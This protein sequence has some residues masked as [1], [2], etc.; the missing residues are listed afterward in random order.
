[1]GCGPQCLKTRKTVTCIFPPSNERSTHAACSAQ[2]KQPYDKAYS[3]TYS[4]VTE[5]E[6]RGLQQKKHPSIVSERFTI[7]STRLFP[8]TAQ[9]LVAWAGGGAGRR[10]RVTT[11]AHMF[12][13][14][15]SPCP[16]PNLQPSPLS[17]TL[18]AP[19]SPAAS[20]PPGP[21]LAPHHMPSLRLGSTQTPCPTPISCS[22]VA[23]GRAPRPSPT[24]RA[25]VRGPAR[26]A[27][28]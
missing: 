19:P 6:T 12:H 1:M 13:V 15:S 28:P 17:C 9:S 24:A 14:R 20:R 3:H 25:G 27:E 7:N 22:S 2:P 16:A 21:H 8:T 23:R 5:R 10:A 18:L 11:M 4:S 26:R